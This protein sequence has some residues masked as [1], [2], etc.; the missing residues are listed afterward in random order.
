MVVCHKKERVKP[1]HECLARKKGLRV[2]LFFPLSMS[3]K[4]S[5][6]VEVRKEFLQRPNVFRRNY[7][8]CTIIDAKKS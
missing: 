8:A 2:G 4:A 7:G 3:G 6:G 5:L 1:C